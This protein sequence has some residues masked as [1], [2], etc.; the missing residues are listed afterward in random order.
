MDSNK[1]QLAIELFSSGCVRFEYVTLK[2]GKI[3]PI[4]IDLRVLI[5]YP[6]VFKKISELFA[7]LID[8]ANLDYDLICGVPYTAIPFATY[9]SILT[10]KPMLMKR[11]E[12]KNYGTKQMIEG[13]FTKDQRAIIIEDIVSS[14]SSVLETVISLKESG[15][16]VKD[17]FVVL[18]RDQGGYENLKEFGIRVHSLIKI[19]ELFKVLVEEKLLEVAKSNE[20]LNW[21]NNTKVNI[22][23]SVIDAYKALEARSEQ[24]KS[25]PKVLTYEER[26][27]LTDN[28]ISKH[29]FRLMSKKSSNLCVAID[30]NKADRILEIAD[31]VGENVVMIKLHCD[32]IDDF[33]QEFVDKL[34]VLAKKHEFLIFEDRK[35]ADIGNTV[36]DQFTHGLYK[37]SEWADLVNCHVISGGGIIDSLKESANLERTGC[38]IVAELSSKGN[39]ITS[40]YT[41]VAVKFAE[42]HSDFVMGFISQSRVSSNP[43]FLHLTPGVNLKDSNDKFDQNYTSPSKAIQVK[44]ADIIIV[45]RGI[46]KSNDPKN[47]S[48]IYKEEAHRAYK[49]I[50]KN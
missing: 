3:S 32:V 49:E 30:E 41:N 17:V 12:A 45:G 14:G 19:D 24:E 26:A 11:K 37:I 16:I 50:L 43:K 21:I 4:Y 40:S 20:V 48:K 22:L 13:R 28:K 38:L 27:E 18:D 33:N 34:K 5:S 2:T 23:D 25:K 31:Q 10:N 8:D 7:G 42:N 15:L 1:K 6:L 44:G 46:S 9:L 29:L 39:L 35:F 47:E 36:K